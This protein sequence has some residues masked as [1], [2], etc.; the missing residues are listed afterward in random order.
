MEKAIAISQLEK[1]YTTKEVLKGIDLTVD[2]GE[3]FVLLGKNG[4][5]KSTLFK[6]L[7]GLAKESGGTFQ[8]FGQKYNMQVDSKKIGF[9][10]NDP[11]FYESLSAKK[12]W[13]FIVPTCRCRIL[14]LIIGYG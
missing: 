6:V 14:M 4:A 2:Q 9:S 1:N 3:I 5:G 8:F 13:K 7:T 11:V 10:I 12:I